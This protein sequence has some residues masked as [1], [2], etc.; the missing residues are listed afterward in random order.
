MA[1]TKEK[2][3]LEDQVET[4]NTN[5]RKTQT[6]MEKYLKK[7]DVVLD[8]WECAVYGATSDSGGNQLANVGAEKMMCNNVE[9][10]DAELAPGIQI[11]NQ[12]K[13]VDGLFET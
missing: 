3:S 6:V 13:H 8:D 4:D 5:K 1:N 7:M 9:H 10:A 2:R 11:C 12:G